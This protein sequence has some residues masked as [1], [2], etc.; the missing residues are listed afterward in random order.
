MR[1]I[2]TKWQHISGILVVEWKIV[3][4]IRDVKLPSN[5]IPLFSEGKRLLIVLPPTLCCEC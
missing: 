5:K 4:I 3:V 2:M 1:K